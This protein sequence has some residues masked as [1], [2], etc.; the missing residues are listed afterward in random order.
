VLHYHGRLPPSG[1]NRDKHNIRQAI[2]PQLKRLWG[3]EQPLIALVKSTEQLTD[4]SR[5]TG[6]EKIANSFVRGNFR[7]VPLVTK[8]HSLVCQLDITF[9]RREEAGDLV[10]HGGDIDNRLKILFDSLRVP[11]VSQLTRLAPIASE[12]PFYCLLEDDSL[13]TGVHVKTERLLEPPAGPQNS[14]DVRLLITAVVRPT[15]IVWGNIGFL[16]GWL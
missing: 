6:L 13:I 11:D 8:S 7:F 15:K 2:H 10:K 12:D 16:G 9:L 4:G 14:K 1:K 3:I 5:V